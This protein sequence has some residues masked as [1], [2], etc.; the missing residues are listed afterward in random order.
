MILSE[1]SQAFPGTT[2]DVFVSASIGLSLFPDDSKSAVEL[3][4]HADAAMYSAKKLGRNNYQFFTHA[5]NEEAH[6][7]M[8]LEAGLRK[9][10]QRDELFLVYQP[11]IDVESRE[12]VGAE[13]LIRWNH[14]KLGLVAP[15]RFI[16]VAEE[17]GMV[18]EIGEWVLRT[19][20]AQIRTW[21]DMNL[22]PQIAVNVSAL[23]FHQ[24][25]LS[26]L[27]STVI[28]EEQIPAESLEIEL[29]ESAVMHDAESSVVTLERLKQLGVRIAI[30]DFGTG[31]SSLSYL[32]RLPLDLLKIDQS[33]VRDISSD[34][35]D[36]AIVRAII[37]LARS[38]GMK[39]TAEG[40]E[41]EAQL[42]F[43]NAYGCEYAQGYL[44]GQ[45]MTAEELTE[46]LRPAKK[47]AATN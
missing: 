21:Q 37:T 2:Q 44:F 43:L 12:L 31:Y 9:A 39:V 28:R 14:P 6:E 17:S 5:L 11:K 41:N 45:P 10:L 23:Q 13:A 19:A 8:M 29:T 20:C 46:R 1:M 35:N 16:P 33:F 4:R 24:H 27:I 38:L 42:A 40:V 18:G 36:A 22:F 30:D 25:D 3:T 34:A 15:A 26:K 7:R 32:K 47:R